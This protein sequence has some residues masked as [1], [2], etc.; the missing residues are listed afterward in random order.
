MHSTGKK[1][2]DQEEVVEQQGQEE[3]EEEEDEEEDEEQGEEAWGE[4]TADDKDQEHGYTS[5]LFCTQQEGDPMDTVQHMKKSHSFDLMQESAGRS[6]YERIRLINYIRNQIL[7]VR[8]PQ[9]SHQAANQDEVLQHMQDKSHFS[10]PRDGA[11]WKDDS[12]LLPT[13]END[14]L[15]HI[16]GECGEMSSDE[17]EDPQ[18]LVMKT[19][20]ELYPTKDNPQA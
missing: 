12:F 18:Q 11:F 3:E 10:V 13:I 15:L 8:C 1:E 6:F 7:N 17:E 19:I 4:W 2:E 14:P 16:V 20:E 5:C 9:C